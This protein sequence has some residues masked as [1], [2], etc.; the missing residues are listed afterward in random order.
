MACTVICAGLGR[1]GDGNAQ[2]LLPTFDA[3]QRIGDL[4]GLIERGNGAVAKEAG[5]RAWSFTPSLD[6]SETYDDGLQVRRSGSRRT[7]SD[8]VTRISPGIGV[9]AATSRIDGSVF[10]TPEIAIYERHGN[11]NT[12]NQNLNGQVTVSVLPG[13]FTVDLRA[14]AAQQSAGGGQASL[15]TLSRQDQVNTASFGITPRLV[16][17]FGDIGSAEASYTLSRT[18]FDGSQTTTANLPGTTGFAG[19][20]S[21]YPST[22]AN[23]EHISFTTGEI[24]TRINDTVSID[25]SQNSG[26]GV[27][28]GA[29]QLTVNNNTTYA[30]TRSI[31]ALVDFGYENI[32]YGGLTQQNIK[33]A[34]WS[35]GA[36]WMPGTDSSLTIKYGKH[37]GNTSLTIDGAMAPSSRTR[38]YVRY[39]EGL[40]TSLQRY[41]RAVAA[42]T[43]DASGNVIDPVTGAPIQLNNNFFGTQPDLYQTSSAS[44]SG[45]ILFNR[46]TVSVS[47]QRDK[48]TL[49]SA[50]STAS[51][52]AY[53]GTTGGT[54]GSV[55]WSREMSPDLGGSVTVQYGVR[56]TPAYLGLSG[57]NQTTL[58][59]NLNLHY[60]LSRTLSASAQYTRANIS[61]AI[62]GQPAGHDIAVV[63]LHKFF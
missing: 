16:H 53:G 35:V 32:K 13:T 36:R 11:Q 3:D 63:S 40:Q 55:T 38:L 44:V 52:A 37:D 50:A 29:S 57:A 25:A 41:Q 4:R 58:T 6:I 18:V 28:Q 23:S 8:F 22:T 21:S 39:S 48:S 51:A 9:T 26:S 27:L 42:S 33:G 24:L 54:S 12:V 34:T 14:A 10:Y 7:V 61:P 1:G 59:F 56:S 5:G 43:V 19:Q 31:S 46:D 20:P 30:V 45:V 17:S 47:L 49:V 60:A 62:A 2:G 15:T